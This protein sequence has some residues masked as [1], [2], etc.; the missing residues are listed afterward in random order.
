MGVLQPPD[1]VP[2]VALFGFESGM[3]LLLDPPGKT[4]FADGAEELGRFLRPTEP[5]QGSTL[6]YVVLR[7]TGARIDSTTVRK[8]NP[9]ELE[10]PDIQ[11]TS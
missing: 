10:S 7:N 8:L 2:F 11:S 6:S 1:D 4:S 9:Q 5:G 3:L